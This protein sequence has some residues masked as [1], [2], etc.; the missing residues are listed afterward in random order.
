MST[1]SPGVGLSFLGSRGWGQMNESL[2]AEEGWTTV[3]MGEA[4][5]S[6]TCQQNP[7]VCGEPVP[8]LDMTWDW[9]K[10][11]REAYSLCNRLAQSNHMPLAG[12][13]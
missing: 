4:I 10:P 8:S 5:P 3:T 13:A 6:T 12:P 11:T 1:G 7:C 9:S 2:Q